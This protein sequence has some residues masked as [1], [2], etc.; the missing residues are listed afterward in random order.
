VTSPPLIAPCPYGIDMASKREFV[1]TDRS[2][3]EV[4]QFLGVERLVY[5]DRNA[6]NAAANAGNPRVEAF[7]NACFSGEYPTG[8]ISVERLSL[9]EAERAQH[10]DRVGQQQ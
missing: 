6:M 9:L 4:A 8:D 10:T 3:E 2:V 5:L 1:A 7:C